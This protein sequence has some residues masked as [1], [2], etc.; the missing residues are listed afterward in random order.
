MLKSI[1]HLVCT[2]ERAGPGERHNT[3]PK[4]TKYARLSISHLRTP[5]APRA[6]IPTNNDAPGLGRTNPSPRVGVDTRLGDALNRLQHHAH[7]AGPEPLDQA[8]GP[9]GLRASYGIA[10]EA[11]GGLRDA[12]C[13]VEDLTALSVVMPLPLDGHGCGG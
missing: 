4:H 10:D 7:H 2:P 12:L 1:L 5:A 11:H 8:L 13:D 3:A 9:V 6:A